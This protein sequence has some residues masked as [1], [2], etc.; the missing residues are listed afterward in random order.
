[1]AFNRQLGVAGAEALA[2]SEHLAKLQ[3]LNLRDTRIGRRG[4]LALLHSTRLPA[5]QWLIVGAEGGGW[6]RTVS[7]AMETRFGYLC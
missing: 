2:A 7:E 4:A 3:T 1:L 6:D 5:L